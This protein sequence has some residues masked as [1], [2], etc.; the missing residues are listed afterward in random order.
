MQYFEK[1]IKMGDFFSM[2]VR[3]EDLGMVAQKVIAFAQEIKIFCFVG[4]LGSGKTTLIQTILRNFGFDSTQITSPTYTYVNTYNHD[5]GVVVYHF[6]LYRIATL[7]SFWAL[8]LQELLEDDKAYIFIEWPEIVQ[9]ILPSSGKL[10]ISLD[11]AQNASE[12]VIT[13]RRD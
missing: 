13:C 2:S 3:Q 12:R 8:G 11:Y 10:I 4:P 9:A 7:E 6:D 1:V 5:N